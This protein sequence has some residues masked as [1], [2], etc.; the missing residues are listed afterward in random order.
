[1]KCNTEDHQNDYPPNSNGRRNDSCSLCLFTLGPLLAMRDILLLPRLETTPRVSLVSKGMI[2]VDFQD[3]VMVWSE[4][5][6]FV[7]STSF[8]VMYESMAIYRE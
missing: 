5:H 1:M 6:L 7:S 2:K 3:S 8:Y 4:H